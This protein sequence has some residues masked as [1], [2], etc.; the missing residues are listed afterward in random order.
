MKKRF[1]LWMLLITLLVVAMA[2]A[3]CGGGTTTT[4]T[5]PAATE[6]PATSTTAAL[7]TDT[8]AATTAT[9]V[10]A[11]KEDTL[12]IGAISSVTG[13]MAPAFKAMF[14]SV[15]P[16]EDLLN[17]MGG[18][19]VGDTHYTIK[20][21][22]YDDQS[23]T[24]GGLTAVNK[25]LGD[26]VRYLV[27]PMFMP[28]NLA[29]APLCEKNKV[30]R[31]KS[32]GAGAAE[33][34]AD[35]PLMFFSCAGVSNFKP[36]YD[37][38]LGKYP[39]VKKVAVISPDDPGAVTYQNMV[40]AEYAAR[41]IEISY[42]E[43]YPL[44]TFDFYALLNKALATKPDAI[45]CIF[46]MPSCC[47]ALINQS[48][49]LGFNGAMFAVSPMG[50]PN[51]LNTMISKPEFAHDI[52]SYVPDVHSD[53]MT[54]PVKKLGESIKAADFQLDSLHLFDACSA[55]IA[56]IQAAQSLDVEK[57]ADAINT[58]VCKGF[59]GSYGPAVWGSYQSVYGNNH[60]AEHAGEMTIFTPQ[61]LQYEWLPWDGTAHDQ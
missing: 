6:A 21:T 49:E 30:M 23:T 5:A 7:S 40:K 44:P 12:T 55:M 14:D 32:L 31:V 37:Y 29:I 9:T 27:P 53:K 16:T 51:A 38:A 19:T 8:T 50:D 54:E 52:L 25:L 43:V 3:A 28:V 57:V 15:K 24:A 59:T 10:A 1:S 22:M 2:A 35:N 11:T 56:A 47:A 41:G 60:V 58:G 4:T 34:N 61:G 33:V 42:W 46:G 39:N 20:I 36:F 17:Q 45:D 26:G 13:D 48:R 18:V